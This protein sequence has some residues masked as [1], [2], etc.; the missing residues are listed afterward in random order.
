MIMVDVFVAIVDF[1][2][3]QGGG[4][5][6]GRSRDDSHDRDTKYDINV[7]NGIIGV[8][9]GKREPKINEIRNQSGANINIMEVGQRLRQ[10]DGNMLAER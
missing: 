2:R 9:I 6:G 5:G 4:R 10:N 3:R 8:V 1:A 7:P